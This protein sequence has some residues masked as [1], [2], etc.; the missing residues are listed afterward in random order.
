MMMVMVI[1][2]D[3]LCICLLLTDS[4]GFCDIVL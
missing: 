1:V 4:L 3:R 2:E